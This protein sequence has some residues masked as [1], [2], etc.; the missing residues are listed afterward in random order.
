MASKARKAFE[1]V[2]YAVGFIFPRE[3]WH[4]R[5]VT[6]ADTLDEVTAWTDRMK[7]DGWDDMHASGSRLYLRRFNPRWPKPD[8]HPAEGRS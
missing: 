7:A 4:V 8:P 5:K 3:E 6:D 2:R 1:W